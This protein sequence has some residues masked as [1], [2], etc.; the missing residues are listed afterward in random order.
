[1]EVNMMKKRNSIIPIMIKIFIYL[2]STVFVVS[3]YKNSGP[4]SPMLHIL[5]NYY[6]I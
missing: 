4:L 1:M 3:G 2:F 5:I 6:E